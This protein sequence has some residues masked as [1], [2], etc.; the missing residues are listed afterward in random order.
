MRAV[1]ADRTGAVHRELHVHPHLS[2]LA[3]ADL[4]LDE[5]TRLLSAFQGFFSALE[6]RRE[7][8]EIDPR[9]GVRPALD[10]LEADLSRLEATVNEVPCDLTWIATP[11]Q[12]LAA[13]YVLHGSAFGAL[14]LGQCVQRSLT[15]VPRSYLSGGVDRAVWAA[16]V[17]A[18]DEAAT[19]DPTA[20]DLMVRAAE[21]T[22]RA[23]GAW[24]TRLCATP[25]RPSRP[26]W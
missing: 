7:A 20:V 21:Q 2:R 25:V 24:I 16:L 11:A 22:F 14:S 17:G 10:R 6:A 9:L 4:R 8:L 3:S 26:G 12:G 23:Y 15:G 13:L 1:L 5:Y 19:A 18:L